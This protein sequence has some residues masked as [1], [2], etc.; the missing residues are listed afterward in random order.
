[1]LQSAKFKSALL[2]KGWGTLDFVRDRVRRTKPG[3]PVLCTFVTPK[4]KAAMR[5]DRKVQQLKVPL[6]GVEPPALTPEQQ[7]ALF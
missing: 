6:H 4:S 7:N 5:L 3:P 1:L 2:R